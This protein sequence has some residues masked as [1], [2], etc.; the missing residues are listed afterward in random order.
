MATHTVKGTYSLDVPTVRA[1]ERLAKRWDVSK[2]E[3]LRRAIQI[4]EQSAPDEAVRALDRLQRSLAL[5]KTAED[6]WLRSMRREREA[7]SDRH[8]R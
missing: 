5:T 8:E 7:S 2:S 4:A 6:G 1:L 3:A